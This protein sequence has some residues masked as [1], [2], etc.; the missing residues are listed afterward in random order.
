MTTGPDIQWSDEKKPE[1]I[2][3]YVFAGRDGKFTLYEDEGTN[4]NYEKGKCAFIDFNYDDADHT[5]TIG[6]R[7]G[8]FNGMLQNRNFNVVLVSSE[9]PASID[10]EVA[11]KAVAY[12]G[13]EVKLSL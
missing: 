9:N 1:N 11:G 2:T 8:E 12:D 5:L 3:V 4:N 6:Q 13:N 7:R 10:T